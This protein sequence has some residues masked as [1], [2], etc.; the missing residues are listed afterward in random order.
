[1]SS[2][3]WRG[4]STIDTR[5]GAAAAVLERAVA[6][7]KTPDPTL[8]ITARC[9]VVAA[10][11]PT[12]LATTIAS[13][14]TVTPTTI[15]RMR[16]ES[17]SFTDNLTPPLHVSVLVEPNASETFRLERTVD[18]QGKSSVIGGAP[19]SPVF[20][21][22]SSAG[23]DSGRERVLEPVGRPLDHRRAVADRDGDRIESA[24]RSDG[25][26]HPQHGV[27]ADNLVWRCEVM[28]GRAERLGADE[29]PALRE[30]KRRDSFQPGAARIAR[31]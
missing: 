19:V 20:A 16:R 3:R 2:A 14:P 21:T 24:Q 31:S 6:P 17:A 10:V 15:L 30:P 11:A 25:G 23:P 18:L 29:Q 5:I 22:T 12:E 26:P 13:D 9:A 4:L 27:D 1:M 7:F 8:R 28:P